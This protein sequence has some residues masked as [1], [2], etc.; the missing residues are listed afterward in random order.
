MLSANVQQILQQ[1]LALPATD[2]A[3]IAEELLSSLDLPDPRI[4]QLWAIE[5]EDRIAAFERGE[6]KTV[7]EDEVFHDL[8]R[9]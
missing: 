3:S 6:M 1:A 7:S 2:R 9:P 5:A 4:D 8:D